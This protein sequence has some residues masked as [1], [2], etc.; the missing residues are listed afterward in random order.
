M[1]IHLLEVKNGHPYIAP[2]IQY[3]WVGTLGFKVVDPVNKNVLVKNVQIRGIVES[4]RVILEAN[5]R[6]GFSR[7]YFAPH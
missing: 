1:G 4:D 5:S 2:A 3:E 7:V 6:S